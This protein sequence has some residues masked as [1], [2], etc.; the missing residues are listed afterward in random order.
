[1]GAHAVIGE[2]RFEAAGCEAILRGMPA[3]RRIILFFDA[4]NL[5]A[6]RRVSE[7]G[8]AKTRTGACDWKDFAEALRISVI[9]A[10]EAEFGGRG[11]GLG[12]SAAEAVVFID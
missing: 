7:D 3:K 4:D 11:D 10:T 8:I 6:S 12:L 2:V 1:M 9:T 5:Q